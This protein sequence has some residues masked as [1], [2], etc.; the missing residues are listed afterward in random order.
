MMPNKLDNVRPSTFTMQ[1]LNGGRPKR[2]A[3]NFLIIAS[4]APLNGLDG[5][6]RHLRLSRPGASGAH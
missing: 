3:D 2:S 5:S 6:T 4:F 1:L